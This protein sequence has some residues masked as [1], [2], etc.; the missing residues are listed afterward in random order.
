MPL[1][2]MCEGSYV[3]LNNCYHNVEEIREELHK[4]RDETFPKIKEH[5]DNN[6]FSLLGIAVKGNPNEHYE[7]DCC[8]YHYCYN[9]EH[10]EIGSQSYY[11]KMKNSASHELLEFILKNNFDPT[12]KPYVKY[13]VYFDREKG[14]FY[15]RVKIKSVDPV[16][17]YRRV[18]LS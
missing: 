16:N 2:D 12:Q 9:I 14:G 7:E 5:I 17:Y 4:L 11:D 15:A 6:I 8:V 1:E 13:H 18:E 3:P 10:V